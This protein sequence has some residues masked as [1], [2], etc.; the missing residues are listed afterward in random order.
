MA[1]RTAGGRVAAVSPTRSS[2]PPLR[3][4]R[5]GAALRLRQSE[6]SCARHS[7]HLFPIVDG[8]VDL[9]AGESAG[10]ARWFDS[11]YGRVYDGGVKH[12]LFAMPF[13][14]LM[15]NT[16]ISEMY[17]LMDE[18]SVCAPGEVVL[19]VPCGGAPV[20][21]RARQIHGTYVGVDLSLEM[22]RHAAALKRRAHNIWLVRA[23][24]SRLPLAAGSVD[25]VLCF[26]GL[27]VMEQKAEV[28]SELA[29]V[30]RRGG[31][32]WGTVLV[33]DVPLR[34]RLLRPWL[35]RGGLFLH[36]ARRDSL[37]RAAREAGFRR[38]EIEG[39]GGVVTFRAE[40]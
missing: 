35:G 12:P 28:L 37:A 31:E 36:P 17:R 40:R 4:P 32:L 9:L 1:G 6:L 18:G 10:S 24:A 2:P 3:C 39:T 11:L 26:N 25:R 23:D 5:C 13:A 14:R 29:R 7:T 22:L 33:G 30:L 34:D 21:A 38:W 19:D 20:L 16:D 15:W 8:V 27:H